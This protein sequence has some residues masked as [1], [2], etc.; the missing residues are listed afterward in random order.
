MHTRLI[1]LKR[2]SMLLGGRI[3]FVWVKKPK[4]NK[5]KQTKNQKK[6]T[7]EQQQK[8]PPLTTNIELII[9]RK[10]KKKKYISKDRTMQVLPANSQDIILLS[11]RLD[12]PSSL[13]LQKVRD[14]K[15][16]LISVSTGVNLHWVNAVLPVYTTNQLFCIS[17]RSITGF[18]LFF[19]TK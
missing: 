11:K 2:P 7:N 3:D 6:P 9:K 12:I 13:E 17:F 14:V 5:N 10:K 19:N 15:G 16:F 8:K 1:V 18:V 4:N